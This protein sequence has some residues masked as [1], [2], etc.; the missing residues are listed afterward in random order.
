MRLSSSSRRAAV[1]LF[2]PFAGRLR[3]AAG[4]EEEHDPA[5]HADGFRGETNY[6]SQ[7][8]NWR[9][10]FGTLTVLANYR[11]YG[12]HGQRDFDETPFEPNV[13]FPAAYKQVANTED[14]AKNFNADVRWTS[15]REQRLMWMA[16]ASYLSENLTVNR[17]SRP[18]WT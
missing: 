14:D 1:G 8:V 13:D 5:Q 4:R 16:G 10:A 6:I 15:P 2:G 17:S 12:R 11:D 9:T 3:H 18:P 7:D